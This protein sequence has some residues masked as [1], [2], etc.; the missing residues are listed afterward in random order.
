MGGGLIAHAGVLRAID[1]RGLGAKKSGPEAASNLE[2]H[3][4]S[5]AG[6]STP[7]PSA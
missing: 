3:Q 2:G 6:F 1:P 7:S 5:P 4:A